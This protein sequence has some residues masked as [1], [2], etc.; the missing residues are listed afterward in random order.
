MHQFE[1]FTSIRTVVIQFTVESNE[2]KR[3]R[4]TDQ[5]WISGY[6]VYLMPQQATLI[7]LGLTHRIPRD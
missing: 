2:M 7:Q 4:I 5:R 3:C 1:A 6:M